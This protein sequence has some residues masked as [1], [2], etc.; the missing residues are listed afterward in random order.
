MIIN[1]FSQLLLLILSPLS[2]SGKSQDLKSESGT[3][4][5][6][7]SY[8]IKTAILIDSDMTTNVTTET[9]LTMEDKLRIAQD[10]FNKFQT[11]CF[12]FMREDLIVTEE[13]LPAIIKG[14]RENGTWETYKIVDRLCR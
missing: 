10:A 12:W 7:L 6:P 2:Q 4:R 5:S 13:D 11:M 8:C 1:P 3:E 9:P 14:L